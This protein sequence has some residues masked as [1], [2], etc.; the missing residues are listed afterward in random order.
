MCK[1]VRLNII[2]LQ[3]IEKII[4]HS[5]KL[6]SISKRIIVQTDLLGD[7]TFI[8]GIAVATQSYTYMVIP[9]DVCVNNE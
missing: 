1:I 2:V 4:I 9:T 8:D 5:K 7:T 3:I 6:Y